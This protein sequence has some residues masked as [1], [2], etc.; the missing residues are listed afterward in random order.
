M[1]YSIDFYE[2]LANR[3][4][5]MS[6]PE[7]WENQSVNNLTYEAYWICSRIVDDSRYNY[8]IW[9]DTSLD[10]HVLFQ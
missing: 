9:K 4:I 1:E 6:R 10:L 8:D 5:K 3:L 2:Y 7:D